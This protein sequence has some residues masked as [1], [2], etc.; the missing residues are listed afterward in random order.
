V[1][2]GSEKGGTVVRLKANGKGKPLTCVGVPQKRYRI[3]RL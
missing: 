2:V 3:Y 1:G